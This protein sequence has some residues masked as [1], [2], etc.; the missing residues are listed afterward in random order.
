VSWLHHSAHADFIFCA[1]IGLLGRSSFW[2]LHSYNLVE[3]YS[4]GPEIQ[5]SLNEAVDIAQNRP[6]LEIWYLCLLL[7]TLGSCLK[8][9]RS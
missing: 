6:L 9:R 7:C 1:A 5:L 3:N 4:A 2:L 8:R